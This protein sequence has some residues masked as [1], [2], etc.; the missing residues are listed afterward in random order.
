MNLSILIVSWNTCDLLKG[1]L[2]STCTHPPPGGY[3]IIVVDN[4]STDGSS[5]MVQGEFPQVRLIENRENLGFA[6]ASNQALAQAAGEYLLLL[7]PDTRV[8]TGS[9]STLLAFMEGHPQAGA[10]GP[11]LLNPD[12]WLQP[13][14]SPEPTL[15]RELW[16]LFHLDVL[17]PYALYPMHTWDPLDPRPVDVIQGACLMLRRE[18]LNQ[19][20]ILDEAY[21]I[22]SEEVDLC[23]RLRKNGWQL[24]WVPQ[25]QVI[26]Y[27]GQSTQQVSAEMF[28]LLYQSKLQY[29]RKHHG[30]LA[31]LAYKM[32]LL[33]AS[34]TRLG[35]SPLAWLEHLPRRAQHLALAQN[36]QR[37]LLEL[38]R[39]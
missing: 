5:Q 37:L 18:A 35:V 17:W 32:I 16:R 3:E 14:C 12:D 38:P 13:S 11:R 24:Y 33:A 7:N 21:F 15:L 27:G 20:G 9:L 34:L 39:M 10:A 30:R 8:Q 26:H 29:F 31:G 19:V 36:Y 4:A 1:C 25:A 23:Y 28:L 2:S 22:Y 6:R